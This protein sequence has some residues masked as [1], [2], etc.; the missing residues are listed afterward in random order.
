VSVFTVEGTGSSLES[1]RT[2]RGRE[3]LSHPP[4][5]GK[6]VADLCS[7]HHTDRTVLVLRRIAFRKIFPQIVRRKVIEEERIYVYD[8]GLEIL[9]P[10]K[11][12]S[13]RTAE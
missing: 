3:Y 7:P 8:F 2:L 1:I 11:A 13:F 10:C 6:S 9:T 4:R 12:F 5:K